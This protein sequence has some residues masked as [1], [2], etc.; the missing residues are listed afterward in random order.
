LT[1]QNCRQ[2]LPKLAE[3]GKHDEGVGAHG[4]HDPLHPRWEREVVAE[5]GQVLRDLVDVQVPIRILYKQRVRLPKPYAQPKLATEADCK[6]RLV[7]TALRQVPQTT[8]DRAA[9]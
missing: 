5:D 4:V 9:R 8:D 7:V 1:S 2:M 3:L 6:A